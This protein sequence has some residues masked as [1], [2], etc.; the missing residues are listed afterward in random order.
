MISHMRVIPHQ[1]SNP[2]SETH[3]GRTRRAVVLS[4][5]FVFFAQASMVV[6]ARVT[7]PTTDWSSV[8]PEK[9][10]YNAVALRTAIGNVRSVG[11]S[12]GMII[13]AGQV[14]ESWG[15]LA[16]KISSHS[17]RKSLSN[18]LYGLAIDAGHMDLDATLGELKIDDGEPLTEEEQSARVRDLLASRSGVYVEAASESPFM[19]STRPERGSHKPGTH[20]YYNNFD[21]NVLETI[22]MEGT[23]R[24]IGD[25]FKT[26]IANPIGMEDFEPDDVFTF[27]SWFSDYPSHTYMI[28]TRDL[29]RFGLLYL[30]DG[31]WCGS[32]ILPAGWVNDSTTSKGPAT[33]TPRIPSSGYGYLWWVTE[34]GRLYPGTRPLPVHAFGAS[35]YGGQNLAV[36]PEYDLVVVYRVDTGRTT[37]DFIWWLISGENL[38]D[39]DFADFLHE[40]LDARH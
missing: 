37:T 8:D 18:A 12:S 10:G 39:S 32:R 9:V 30:Y 3:A 5:L 33:W 29:A 2:V 27:G 6:D 28:S 15:D 4:G 14:I 38:K 22:L 7:C 21:F 17:V 19:S 16:L 34:E 20:F 36:V 25:L 35:G 26:Q 40:V 13:V 24:G 1:M 11:A 23:G 31:E